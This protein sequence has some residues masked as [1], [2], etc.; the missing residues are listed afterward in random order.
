MYQNIYKEDNKIVALDEF[1]NRHVFDNNENTL[2][3][4]STK[5]N[6]EVL[7]NISESYN[8]S[9]TKI[10]IKKIINLLVILGLGITNVVIPF[11]P[12]VFLLSII[13]IYGST[14]I[15]LI[16]KKKYKA[17][18]EIKKIIKE[19]IKKEYKILE[20]LQTNKIETSIKEETKFEALTPK[21]TDLKNK[22][23]LIKE[24]LLNFKTF[25]D[26]RQAKELGSYLEEEGF[27]DKDIFFIIK[28]VDNFE[29]VNEIIEEDQ[30]QK[31]LI[32]G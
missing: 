31:K 8:T 13:S 20:K 7:K 4:L 9:R 10:S 30:K 26:Y 21:I 1:K 18:V 17:N 16:E 32:K 5:N 15:Y 24:Y 28:I 6:I 12:L 11:N 2:D 19:Q 3:I 22:L 14:N 29:Q 25:N 27:S 23:E